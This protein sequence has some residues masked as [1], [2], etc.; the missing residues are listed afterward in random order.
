[1]DKVDRSDKV[2]HNDNN[3]TDSQNREQTELVLKY[4]ADID[5]DNLYDTHS[6]FASNTTHINFLIFCNKI[7]L[8][9]G[10]DKVFQV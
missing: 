10:S 5:G 8:V 4:C 2:G 9:D 3:K 1:M 7:N 6:L